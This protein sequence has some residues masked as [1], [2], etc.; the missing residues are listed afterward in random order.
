MLKHLVLLWLSV[1]LVVVMSGHM[2]LWVAV[3]GSRSLPL[4]PAPSSETWDAVRAGVAPRSD[5]AATIQER[6]WSSPIQFHPAGPRR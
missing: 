1:V 4:C 6:A 5:L 3:I 2:Y